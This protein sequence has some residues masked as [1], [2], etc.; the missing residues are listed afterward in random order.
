VPGVLK[1]KEECWATGYSYSVCQKLVIVILMLAITYFKGIEIQKP[2]LLAVFTTA[3]W[4][5]VGID[6]I[7]TVQLKVKAV[8]AHSIHESLCH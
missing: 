5:I 2:T 1:S 6:S 8:A 7:Y 4:Y 3:D